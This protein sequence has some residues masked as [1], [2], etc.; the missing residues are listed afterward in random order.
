MGV[1]KDYEIVTEIS[2]VAVQTN[3]EK[4]T[5]TTSVKIGGTGPAFIDTTEKGIQQQVPTVDSSCQNI[6]DKMSAATSTSMLAATTSDSSTD[7]VEELALPPKPK[8]V[9][10]STGMSRLVTA[11]SGTDP[12]KEL[13]YS[14]MLSASTSTDTL[15]TAD[16]GT[17]P[18]KEL[19]YSKMLSTS[20]STDKLVTAD[21]GTD[22][23]KELAY[24]KMLSASTSTNKLV[25]ADSGT[26]PEKINKSSVGCQKTLP[27]TKTLHLSTQTDTKNNNTVSTMAGCSTN[28]FSEQGVGRDFEQ[29]FQEESSQTVSPSLVTNSC[30][31]PQ[32]TFESVSVMVGCPRKQLTETAVGSEL[33]YSESVNNV[34]VMVGCASTQLVETCV[35]SDLSYHSMDKDSQTL[36]RETKGNSSQTDPPPTTRCNGVQASTEINDFSCG[37][38]IADVQSLHKSLSCSLLAQPQCHVTTSTIGMIVTRDNGVQSSPPEH[39]SVAVGDDFDDVNNVI[40]DQCTNLKTCDTGVGDY[41]YNDNEEDI[42]YAPCCIDDKLCECVKP[43]LADKSTGEFSLTDTFCDKCDNLQTTEVGVGESDTMTVVW[44]EKCTE[45]RTHDACVGSNDDVIDKCDSCVQNQSIKVSVETRTVAVGDYDITN[46]KCGECEKNKRDSAYFNF[47]F[48][49]GA[50]SNGENGQCS[51]CQQQQHQPIICHY[52]GN[53]VDLNDD[54]MDE[55]LQAMRDSMQ[56][57]SAASTGARSAAGKRLQQQQQRGELKRSGARKNLNLDLGDGVEDGR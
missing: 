4:K 21:S 49:M 17:N 5:T 46:T 57:M 40:C 36:E 7:P 26:D 9:D 44:C 39:V 31:T 25:T 35:G 48:N 50:I 30:Q 38:N 52:C 43:E 51:S 41:L 29:S 20:T 14:K 33:S 23:D 54:S 42:E 11:D 6:N 34:S 45:T 55:T 22:P 56:S 32:K 1:Q 2:H 27:I 12:D 47:D 28:D 37:D 3:S 18:D 13:F 16:S 10:N 15:V 8:L 24:S 53:K 19:A